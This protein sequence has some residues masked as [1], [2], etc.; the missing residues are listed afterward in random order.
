MNNTKFKI[1]TRYTKKFINW[2]L[3]LGGALYFIFTFVAMTTIP[4]IRS[5]DI[6]HGSHISTAKIEAAIHMSAQFWQFLFWFPIVFGL[7]MTIL[8]SLIKYLEYKRTMKKNID[9]N[10]GEVK[11]D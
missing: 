10:A 11:D 9:E 6:S 4:T 5:S 8:E 2:A 7:V 3:A 1:F